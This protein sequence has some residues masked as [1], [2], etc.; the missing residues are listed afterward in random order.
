MSAGFN[1]RAVP[2]PRLRGLA[3]FVLIG[4]CALLMID[5]LSTAAPVDQ[6]ALHIYFIDVEGGQATLIVTPDQ[7]SLLIDSGWAGAGTGYVPGDTHQARDANRILA[8]AHDAGLSSIDAALITHFHVDH[9][10]GIGELSR[11]L[12]IHAFIDHGSPAPALIE[13]DSEIRNAFA[14]YSSLRSGQKHLEPRV[15]DRLPL[16]R[17]DATIVSTDGKTIRSPLQSRGRAN[18]ACSRPAVPAGDLLENPRSTGLLLRYGRFRF[19]DLGDLSGK[20]LR[21]LVCP[22]SLIGPVDVYLVAHHGGDDNCDPAVFNGFH[23]RVAILNNGVRKGGARRTFETLHH[24]ENLKDVWQLHLSEHA[25][26]GNFPDPFVANLDEST[27]YWIK[28]A[29]HRDGSFEI[30]NA[31]TGLSKHY[32]PSE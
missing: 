10:G 23:P 3:A 13:K 31:R 9:M 19:L 4:T 1:G 27:A 20:P 16:Q 22:A 25:G 18:L 26:D 8:A 24:L 5:R 21:R 15:G 30:I 2:T 28:L 29:A 7:G 17:I 14:V 12:P 32:A 6:S 11:L